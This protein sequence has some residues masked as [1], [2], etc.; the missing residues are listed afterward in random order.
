MMCN[1]E[2]IKRLHFIPPDT[3]VHTHFCQERGTFVTLVNIIYIPHLLYSRYVKGKLD[4]WRGQ[5]S[6]QERGVQNEMLA[7]MKGRFDNLS[8]HR[9]KQRPCLHFEFLCVHLS[10]AALHGQHATSDNM[11]SAQL[12]VTH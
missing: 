10:A 4:L 9:Q 3:L 11:Q 2:V 12:G 8:K 7:V 5:R 1:R 6:V